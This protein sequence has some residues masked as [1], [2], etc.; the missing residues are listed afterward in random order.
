[1]PSIIVDL[2]DDDVFILISI[3]GRG[4]NISGE[5]ILSGSQGML[6]DGLPLFWGEGAEGCVGLSVFSGVLTEVGAWSDDGLLGNGFV[7]I[8]GLDR[9]IAHGNY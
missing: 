2:D 7:K 3:D 4:D 5:A 8:S 6:R 1:M 9:K